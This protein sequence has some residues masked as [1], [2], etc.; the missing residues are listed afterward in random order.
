MTILYKMYTKCIHCI[1]NAVIPYGPI[2]YTKPKERI[3][4]LIKTWH[5]HIRKS[6]KGDSLSLVQL[7][8]N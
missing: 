8:R 5:S 6:I 4:I 3:L 2:V 1:Y 7:I